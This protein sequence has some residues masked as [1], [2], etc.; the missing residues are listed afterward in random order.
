V[1]SNEQG[2]GIL[3]PPIPRLVFIGVGWEPRLAVPLARGMPV[4]LWSANHYPYG[5]V[6]RASRFRPDGLGR[7]R[8]Q[9]AL[10][11]LAS[12]EFGLVLVAGD[13]QET[14]SGRYSQWQFHIFPLSDVVNW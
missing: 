5:A 6:H 10:L 11:V 13:S 1:G 14:P 4:A 7:A 3:L 12:Q 2:A 9:N 8:R